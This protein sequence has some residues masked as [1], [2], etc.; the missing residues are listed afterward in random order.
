MKSESN[1]LRAEK[2]ELNFSQ[3]LDRSEGEV[4]QLQAR[5]N[6]FGMKETA[7]CTVSP[8]TALTVERKRGQFE[9]SRSVG[10]EKVLRDGWARVWMHPQEYPDPVDRWSLLG[11]LD[12]SW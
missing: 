7:Q 10:S 11:A 8:R 12:Q 2:Q 3:I 6:E 9:H 4:A 5:C 1:R